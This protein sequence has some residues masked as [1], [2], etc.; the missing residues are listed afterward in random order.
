[1]SCSMGKRVRHMIMIYVEGKDSVSK[2]GKLWELHFC[3]I[4]AWEIQKPNNNR[5]GW[6]YSDDLCFRS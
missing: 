1:M 2:F 3:S 4:Y 6:G 5:G